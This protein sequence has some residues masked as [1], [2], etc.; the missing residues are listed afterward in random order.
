MQLA[1]FDIILAN[2]SAGKDSLAMLLHLVEVARQQGVPL[3]RI[4]AVHCDLGRV[5]W[6][7]TRALAQRQAE[8]LGLRFE[9]VQ[10]D[11]DLLDQ[12]VTRHH[13]LVRRA[14]DLANAAD[15]LDDN[16]KLEAILDALV[17]AKSPAARRIK[18]Q[19]KRHTITADLLR[20]LSDKDRDNPRWM[21]SQNRYCTSDQ[22]TGQVV[23]LMTRLVN[24]SGIKHRRVRIL[25]CLGIRAAESTKRSD[26]KQVSKD[27]A[28]N[29]TKR[30]VT[31]Y[32]P[33][34]NWSVDQ[35]WA[36][37]DQA[38]AEYHPAYDLGMPRLS[39]VFC[40]MAGRKALLLAASHNRKLLAQ[41][42]AVE[43]LVGKTFKKDEPLADI[44]RDLVAGVAVPTVIPTWEA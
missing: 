23:K 26:L 6:A 40:P 12:V 38:D 37:I 27:A 29:K 31:R 28:T 36:R 25:N 2:T 22:K 21:D 18:D 13:T 9:V 8:A 5:E 20:E 17:K 1:D 7:D 11:E 19:A 41:Y 35:V 39:C 24:E 33:I 42:V 32:Y 30:E 44:E 15:L 4:I 14:A 16:V 43:D 34:F 3:N 10:R